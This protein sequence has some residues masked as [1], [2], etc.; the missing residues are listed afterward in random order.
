MA[1][2][3]TPALLRRGLQIFLLISLAGFAATLFY[4]KD[5]AQS[6]AALRHLKWPWLLVGLGLASMDWIGGGLRLWVVARV[7]HPNPPLDALRAVLTGDAL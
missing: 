5:P 4:G 6:L 3:F 2:L 1:R 7:V